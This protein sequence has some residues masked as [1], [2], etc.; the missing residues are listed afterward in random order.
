VHGNFDGV[1]RDEKFW[2]VFAIM[3]CFRFLEI[4]ADLE[5]MSVL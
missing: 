1:G 3:V 5:L 2:S 4:G